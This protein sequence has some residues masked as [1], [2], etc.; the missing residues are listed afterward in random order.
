LLAANPDSLSDA[1]GRLCVFTSELHMVKKAVLFLVCDPAFWP[2]FFFTK[3]TF[4]HENGRGH[5]PNHIHMH[6]LEKLVESQ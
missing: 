5:H 1:N 6:Y 2:G 4:A 3:Q